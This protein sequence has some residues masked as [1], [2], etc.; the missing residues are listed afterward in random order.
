MYVSKVLLGLFIFL[1]TGIWLTVFTLIAVVSLPAQARGEEKM[2]HDM[3]GKVFDDYAA[4]TGRFLPKI[5][6]H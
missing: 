3:F 4:K 5:R 1:A 6:N 2:L